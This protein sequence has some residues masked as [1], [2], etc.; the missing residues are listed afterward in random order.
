MPTRQNTPLQRR[1]VPQ[2]QRTCRGLARGNDHPTWSASVAVTWPKHPFTPTCGAPRSTAKPPTEQRK[3]SGDNCRCC[4][5]PSVWNNPIPVFGHVGKSQLTATRGARLPMTALYKPFQD[6]SRTY[7]LGRLN[8][9]IRRGAGR[10]LAPLARPHRSG[11]VYVRADMSMAAFLYLR[12]NALSWGGPFFG[13]CWP[14]A[15]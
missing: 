1:T 6:L 8:T 11:V 14:C 9:Q 7:S 13:R 5:G 3:P 12:P 2:P 4:C 10:I 15:W